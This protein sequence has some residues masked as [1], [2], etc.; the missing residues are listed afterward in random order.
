M[1]PDPIDEFIRSSTPPA[2]IPTERVERM[3][4]GVMA[5][6]DAGSARPPRAAIWGRL[7][8]AYAAPIAAAA[9]LGVFVGH[10]LAPGGDGIA[11]TAY[12]QVP[13]LTLAGFR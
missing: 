12:F 6:L 10:A 4:D 13:S 3:I 9:L 8:G 2:D 5:R 7:F 11:V 1:S